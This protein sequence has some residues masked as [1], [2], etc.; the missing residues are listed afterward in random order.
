[1]PANAEAK[2]L[3]S[4]IHADVQRDLNDARGLL[5]QAGSNDE[6]KKYRKAAEIILLKTLYMDPEHEGAKALLQTAR[7]LKEMPA[8]R[9]VL[10]PPPAPVPPRPAPVAQS[11]PSTPRSAVLNVPEPAPVPVETPSPSRTSST[12][13]SEVPFYH[14]PPPPPPTYSSSSPS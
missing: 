6:V 8:P 9:P 14:T 12:P 1:D 7:N 11:V 13:T 3:Q 10:V 2:A 4:A 5:E